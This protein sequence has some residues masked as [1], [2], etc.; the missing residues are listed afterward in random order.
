MVFEPGRFYRSGR[1]RRI[2]VLG[3]LDTYCW[4]RVL[5]AEDK[6]GHFQPCGTDKAS[7][8]G[9]TEITES[10]WMAPLEVV[11]Q[12]DHGGPDG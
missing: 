11:D 5:L 8:Q 12:P 7:T 6:Y 4:G 9:W 2:A 1:G 3:Y 10:E